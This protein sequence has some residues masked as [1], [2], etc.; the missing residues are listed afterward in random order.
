MQTRRVGIEEAAYVLQYVGGLRDSVE[1]IPDIRGVY[2][3]SYTI[4]VSNC[5]DSSDN[6]T[7]IGSIVVDIPNQQ[8]ELFSGTAVGTVNIEGFNV[9]ENI[10]LW[11]VVTPS[12]GVSGNT[13]HTFYDSGGLGTFS[14]QLTGNTLSILNPGH[15]TYGDTCSYTRNITAMRE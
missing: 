3:G 15:D 8:G 1:A 14:G 9:Y 11:G 5:T 2:T 10:T 7:Y 6:G 12:G 13:S 4:Q